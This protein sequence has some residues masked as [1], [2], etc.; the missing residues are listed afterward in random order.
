MTGTLINVSTIVVGT[1]IGMA[2]KTRIPDHMSQTVMGGL[3]I[4]TIF[5]GFSMALESRNMLIVLFSIVL[6][7]IIGSLLNINGRLE[8]ATA[9]LEARFAKEGSG[10]AQGFL[11][12]SLLFCVGP[13]A[14]LGSI[15]DGLTGSYRI[16]MTKSI[17]D[18]FSSL[19]F[20]ATMGIGVALSSL[21]LL[22]YQGALTLGASVVKGAMTDSA[23]VEMTATG[24]LLIVSIG[25]NMLGTKKLLVADMLPAI[26]IAVILARLVL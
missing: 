4:F 17:M 25:I 8:A 18:G 14:I 9:K 3:G 11:A 13:M 22:I 23:M 16:L 20:G 26:V 24:G 10:L 21:P 19:V 5:V 2:V 1:F 6:G 12:A 7:T 15:E